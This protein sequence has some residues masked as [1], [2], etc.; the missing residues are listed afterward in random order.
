[1]QNLWIRKAEY[2]WD[3]TSISLL[4]CHNATREVQLEVRNEWKRETEIQGRNKFIIWIWKIWCLSISKGLLHR[5]SQWWADLITFLWFQLFLSESSL[6]TSLTTNNLVGS[7]EVYRNYTLVSHGVKSSF[8][9]PSLLLPYT[10]MEKAT[11]LLGK[12]STHLF[13]GVWIVTKFFKEQ[14]EEGNSLFQEWRDT[15]PFIIHE[16][17]SQY[18]FIALI[19]WVYIFQRL[20]T[21]EAGYSDE[22]CTSCRRNSTVLARSNRHLINSMC[23]FYI[24]IAPCIEYKM[25]IWLQNNGHERQKTGCSLIC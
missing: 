15:V 18:W 16:R 3:F 13:S 10:L 24:G 5:M 19:P 8:Y 9:S 20:A 21:L 6:A 4:H 25:S 12:V 14:R 2:V 23:I 7:Q 22:Y 1:M 11:I 17:Y